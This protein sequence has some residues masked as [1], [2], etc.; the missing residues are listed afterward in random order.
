[1]PLVFLPSSELFFLWGEAPGGLLGPL[2]SR[3]STSFAELVVPPGQRATIPGLVLAPADVI[4]KLAPLTGAALEGQPGSTQ[5]WAR[6]SRLAVEL[7]VEGKVVPG[8]V[9]EGA[10]IE[11]RW[12]IWGSDA[13]VKAQLERLEAAMP[14]AAHA[15]PVAP[16]GDEAWPPGRLLRAFLDSAADLLVRSAA[17][18]ARLPPELR[19]APGENEKAALQ[20]KTWGKRWGIKLAT[21][22][23]RL[24]AAGFI[25]RRM[26][27]AVSSWS[28]P[29]RGSERLR[30]A[31][32]L[33]FPEKEDG[34]FLLRILLQS[35]DDPSL[36][37]TAAEVWQG[38]GAVRKLGTLFQDPEGALLRSLAQA[39]VV[40]PPVARALAFAAPEAVELDLQ[41]A[42][43]FLGD[44]AKRL[45]AAGFG[46]LVPGE[47]TAQ[48]RR[49]QLQMDFGAFD[50]MAERLLDDEP[51][52]EEW[53]SFEW[54]IA[55]G[56]DT[57]SQAEFDALARQK[58]PLVKHRGQWVMLDLDELP[59]IQKRLKAGRGK[60]RTREG[61]VAALGG[62]TTVEGMRVR[63]RAVNQFARLLE[64]L[65][66]GADR[67]I[68]PPAGLKATLRPYQQRGLAWLHTMASLGLGGCLADDMGLGKTVQLLAFM[69][70]H[71]E[72]QPKRRPKGPALL[73]APTSVVGNWER[74]IARFAPSISVVNHYGAGRATA[75]AELTAHDGKLV[76]TTYSLLWRDGA[77][78]KQVPWWLVALDE[79]Q[80]IKNS[81][82]ATAQAAR[83]LEARHRF[84]LT[85][86]PVEN[87][88]AELW[89]ILDF[90]NPGLLGSEDTFQKTFAA[91][92]ERLNDA[93]AAGRLRRIVAPFVLRRHK[94]DP[95]IAPDLPEKDEMKVYC[96]LTR[97]QASLYK[98]TVDEIMEAIR[99]AQGIARKGLILAL[100]TKLKQICNH[101]AHFLRET[102]PLLR[103]SGKLTRL[104]EMLAE[105]LAEGER[106]LIF[107]QF[108]EMGELLVKHL[109]R[110][111]KTEVIYL[112]GETPRALRDEMVNRFQQAGDKDPRIFLLSLKAGGTG[113]NLTAASQVFHYDRWWNPA[114]EDQATDRAY[115][116]GQTHHVQV[117]KYIC[118]GTIEE[119]IDAMIDKKKDL[120]DRV[121]GAGENWIT[122]LGDGELRELFSLSADAVQEDD[123][124]PVSK[125]K[126][127][128]S[129]AKKA[130]STPA[131]TT[132]E[133]PTPD[134][135][136]A[137][138]KK[139]APDTTAA[140]PKKAAGKARKG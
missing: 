34:P 72:M 25:E 69:L 15:V 137:T 110:E 116:I 135:T 10:N 97:E 76:L 24:P 89:S 39:A 104:T 91:P 46:V 75:P 140:A 68:A 133:K 126:K 31:F 50:R 27:E 32:R 130:A 20:E 13:R 4:P 18:R 86:T 134:T 40:F 53:L 61:L 80:N 43:D 44:G 58:M 38:D 93:S 66:G 35:A 22:D 57:L 33:E 84:A 99:S 37:V 73:V 71:Q 60:M 90:T 14:P 124:Q 17:V 29:A 21:P 81:D 83:E 109:T 5:F 30:G 139:P 118:S 98:A 92:I 67:E 74:E 114:V 11:A 47:L 108:R 136:A 82:T 131:K 79:A 3:A 85:G 138:P 129:T 88:L 111:L 132:P 77:V 122:E 45:A 56:D 7:V 125:A 96:S 107:S 62:E 12:G 26:A 128:A 6:A 119:K 41:G 78:L 36:Q 23:R 113:L 101:P 87:R 106:A 64:R 52:W 123:P 49:V 54:K 117:F 9:R 1:M 55:I 2:K 121:I 100:L 103:R 94:S 8:V 95:T 105:T 48:G 120:A 59:A 102:G 51:T 28:D 42:C 63:A 16:S 112:H 65:R 127:S 19:V 115:R 70:K